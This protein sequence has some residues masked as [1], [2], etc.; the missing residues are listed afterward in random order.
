[1]SILG[2]V[3]RV[4]REHLDEI[5]QQLMRVP[6]VD[7]APDAG[8]GRLAATIESTALTPAAA[9]MGEMAQWPRVLSLSLVFE[10]SEPEA[11]EP[12]SAD[13][14]DSADFD[15][16]AWRGAVGDFARRQAPQPPLSPSPVSTSAAQGAGEAR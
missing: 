16:R 13:P 3:I 4:R 9:T 5:R 6:G 7:L 14:A 12:G 2:I 8:D 11:A 15:F 1:M 10:H